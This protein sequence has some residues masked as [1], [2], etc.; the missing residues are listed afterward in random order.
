M[1]RVTVHIDRLVLRGHRPQ[2]RH[3]LAASLRGELE[4]LLAQPQTLR[5]L[6]SLGHRPRIDAGSVRGLPAAGPQGLGAAIARA[7]VGSVS[8]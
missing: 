4:R 8:R 3:P 5:A 7:I 2:D 6:A 1:K